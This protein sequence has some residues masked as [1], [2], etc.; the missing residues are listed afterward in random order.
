MRERCAAAA[1]RLCGSSSG[2]GGAA[3]AARPAAAGELQT[4]F[5]Q[6]QKVV[7]GSCCVS[8][9]FVW[10]RWQMDPLWVNMGRLEGG[11]AH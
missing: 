6:N 4:F 3:D 7:S 11:G 8:P 1:P 2:S 10:L 9:L 5:F